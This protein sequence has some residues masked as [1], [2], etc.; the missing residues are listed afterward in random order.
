MLDYERVRLAV[1]R[2][3]V[4][5]PSAA[6][7]AAAFRRPFFLSSSLRFYVC[8]KRRMAASLEPLEGRTRV[9]TVVKQVLRQLARIENVP[10]LWARAV[11]DNV[12]L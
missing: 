1:V 9:R 5:E 6:S 12:G 10:G 11:F 2:P 4:V 8:D 7:L 3:V